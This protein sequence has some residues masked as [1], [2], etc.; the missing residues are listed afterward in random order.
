MDEWKSCN[1]CQQ[2]FTAQT[3]AIKLRRVQNWEFLEE[4]EPFQHLKF[5]QLHYHIGKDGN[6]R[7]NN[8]IAHLSANFTTI[9]GK[10]DTVSGN[11]GNPQQNPISPV[12]PCLL[13]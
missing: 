1:F 8:W 13:N 2:L 4:S 9:S 3:V 10:D 7:W 5:S 11:G 6:I 12:S